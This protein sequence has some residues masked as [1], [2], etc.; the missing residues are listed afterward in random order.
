M[1]KVKT[2]GGSEK[3]WVYCLPGVSAM[4]MTEWK[5]KCVAQGEEGKE[6]RLDDDDR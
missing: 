6:K 2:E 1:K 3:D 4:K 5:S